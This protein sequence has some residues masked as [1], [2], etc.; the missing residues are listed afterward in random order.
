MRVQGSHHIYCRSGEPTRISVP[1]HG[2]RDIK[3]GLLRSFM[4]QAGVSESEL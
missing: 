1:I 3:M 4:K 2:N